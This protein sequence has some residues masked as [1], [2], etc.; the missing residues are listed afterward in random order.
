MLKIVF[1]QLSIRLTC[2]SFSLR[3]NTTQIDLFITNGLKAK[4]LLIIV[5]SLLSYLFSFMKDAYHVCILQ[6]I[7]PNSQKKLCQAM[8]SAELSDEMDHYS[9]S[10]NTLL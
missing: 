7:S 5:C 4:P 10:F 2:F 6:A 8:E 1:G 3:Q 9:K